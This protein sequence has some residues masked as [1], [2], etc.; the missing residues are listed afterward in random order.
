MPV[1]VFLDA[2][3]KGGMGSQWSG[4]DVFFL[5]LMS[6][7]LHCLLGWLRQCLVA[8][9]GPHCLIQIPLLLVCWSQWYSWRLLLVCHFQE[10]CSN[11]DDYCY[12]LLMSW[13]Q[14]SWLCL[15]WWGWSF[16]II[17]YPILGGSS[18]HMLHIVFPKVIGYLCPVLGWQ[19]SDVCSWDITCVW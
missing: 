19:H 1:H 13:C 17:S 2:V 14:H 10:Y 16:Y 11:L 15:G 18:H 7:Y 4:E 9:V 3:I 8:Y 6:C 12:Q 5:P